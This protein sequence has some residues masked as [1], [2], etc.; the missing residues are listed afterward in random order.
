ME[1]LDDLVRLVHISVTGITV[2]F[3]LYIWYKYHTYYQHA[4]SGAH[5]G[6]YGLLILS[7]ALLTWA[8]IFV[9][10]YYASGPEKSSLTHILSVLNNGLFLCSFP[11]FS[12]GFEKLKEN[13][14]RVRWFLIIISIT[15]FAIILVALASENNS[16]PGWVTAS[17]FGLS[18]L[19]ILGMALLLFNTFYKRKL[20]GVA[21]L[22]TLIML[23]L[24]YGQAMRAFQP[25]SE[26]QIQIVQEAINLTSFMGMCGLFISLALTWIFE[27]SNNLNDL[28]FFKATGIDH[29]EELIQH[30]ISNSELLKKIDEFVENDLLEELIRILITHFRSNGG[31]TKLHNVLSLAAQLSNI[32][33]DRI[34][35]TIT[36]ETYRLERS[37]IRDSV[38]YFKSNI[39]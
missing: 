29:V 30:P 11:F 36:D 16:V 12:H 3:L 27:L 26:R 22:T 24:V 18:A 7:L 20:L 32:N 4:F 15:V 23:L 17:S 33:T 21:I 10:P 9:A 1:S 5:S 39:T 38:L 13:K 8:S 34:R 6:D 19:T 31:T 37:R 25:E 2:F 14:Y 28:Y 35:N